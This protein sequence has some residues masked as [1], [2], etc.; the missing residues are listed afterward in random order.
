M[1]YDMWV[2]ALDAALLRDL[3]FPPVV[4]LHILFCLRFFD[5]PFVV[6]ILPVVV[7]VVGTVT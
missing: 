5:F 3:S 6:V 1:L 7:V 2:A 4:L